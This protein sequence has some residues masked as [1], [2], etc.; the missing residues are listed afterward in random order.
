[1]IDKR[2]NGGAL[3]IVGGWE[4][5]EALFSLKPQRIFFKYAKNG[6][7][8]TKRMPAWFMTG[9]NPSQLRWVSL[10]DEEGSN[11]DVAV[12]KEVSADAVSSG[13]AGTTEHTVTC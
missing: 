13:K 2:S 9:K 6:S 5:K 12:T 10:P 7:Q 11:K 3:W 4:L 1:M 8:S